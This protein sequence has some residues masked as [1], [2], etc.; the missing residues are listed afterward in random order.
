MLLNVINVDP[1]VRLEG[2][3]PQYRVVEQRSREERIL[4]V[5][6]QSKEHGFEVRFWP[7]VTGNKFSQTNISQSFKKIVQWAKTHSEP[8]VTIAED[9]FL[10]TAPGACRY[11]FYNKPDRYDLYLG[12]IYSGQIK[13][14]RIMNGYSG[15]TL[16][17]V[18]HNFYDNILEAKETD[19]LDRWLG[20]FAFE[21]EYI[22]C[23]PFVVKQ[24]PGY[25]DNKKRMAEYSVFEE[26]F[27]YFQSEP[28]DS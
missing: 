9:D 5:A 2:V 12:G 19:H 6:R 18:H 14:N 26:N 3:N 15:N 11:Y 21:R 8:F 23:L 16:V 4:S 7:G 28:G 17:T 20:N 10:F 27:N 25:S 22:V 13:G 24:I 1:S